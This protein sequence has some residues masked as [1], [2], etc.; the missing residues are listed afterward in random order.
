[1]KFENPD[2]IILFDKPYG[3]TSFDIVKFLKK[4]TGLA[5]IG[6][7]GTLDP[8]ATGLLV[9]C[10]GKFTKKISE[11]QQLEKEYT[12]TFILGAS[13]PSYDMETEIDKYFEISKLTNEKIISICKKFVGVI[14]QTPPIYSAVKVNGKRAYESARK[15]EELKI[16]SR[17]VEIKQFEITDIR[18]PAVDFKVVCS[19]GTYIR[20]LV[21]DIGKELENGAYLSSLRRTKIGDNKVENA[22]CYDD[23]AN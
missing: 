16:E 7:A 10:T 3:K 2:N 20:S 22:I 5:K 4:Q 23:F 15:G 13:R 18:I 17:K 9:L 21:N 1:M 14:D 12:G 6:H 19:K 11:I 8:L